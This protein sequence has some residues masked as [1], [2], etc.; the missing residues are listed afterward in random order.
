MQAFA[1]LMMLLRH[2]SWLRIHLRW[3]HDSLSSSG[4]DELLQ[5]LIEHLNFSLENSTQNDGNLLLILSRTSMLICQ[6][7]VVLNVEWK[8]FQRL[9]RVR[10]SWLLYLIA[11]ITG[12]LHLL[13]QLMS[14]QEPRF[15]LAIS[16]ILMLKKILLMILTI[17]LKDFQS[18]RLLDIL[19]LSNDYLYSSFHHYLKYFINLVYLVFFLHTCSI[20]DVNKLTKSSNLSQSV[21][22][23]ASRF[24]IIAIVSL[25]KVA[26]SSLFF[27]IWIKWCFL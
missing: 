19:Y 1:M 5:L 12:S 20:F 24:F 8:V 4:V 18:L 27:S 21:R 17:F 23:E 9:S 3:F 22:L 6:W 11:L 26:S 7:R 13:T 14:S 25:T 10:H 16:W 2:L 15:L